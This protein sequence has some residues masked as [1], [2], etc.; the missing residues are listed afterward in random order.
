MK[1]SLRQQIIAI[2]IRGNCCLLLL[3]DCEKKR[4]PTFSSG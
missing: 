2:A 3:K 4:E 1:A